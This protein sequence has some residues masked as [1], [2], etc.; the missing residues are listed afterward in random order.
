MPFFLVV[1]HIDFCFRGRC[2]TTKNENDTLDL[3][4]NIVI[5]FIKYTHSYNYIYVSCILNSDVFSH[6]LTRKHR[7]PQ[8]LQQQQKKFACGDLKK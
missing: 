6:K 3:I 4:W 5:F 8:Q 7:Q 1:I 2:R